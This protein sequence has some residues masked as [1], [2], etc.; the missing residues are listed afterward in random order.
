MS[1]K[2]TT[3]LEEYLQQLESIGLLPKDRSKI[4]IYIQTDNAGKS[5]EDN[6]EKS[7]K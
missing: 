1:G 5:S 3:T 6:P 4:H 7:V 2:T